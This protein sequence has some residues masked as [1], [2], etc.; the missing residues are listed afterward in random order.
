MDQEKYIIIFC[1]RILWNCCNVTVIKHTVL[2]T[3]K[4][5]IGGLTTPGHSNK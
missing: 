1:G 5:F 3:V 2:N 4:S